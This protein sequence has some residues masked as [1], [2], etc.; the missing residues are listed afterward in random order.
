VILADIGA[1]FAKFV[2]GFDECHCTMGYV[3]ETAGFG[4]FERDNIDRNLAARAYAETLRLVGSNDDFAA[5][6]PR[7][8]EAR[9][10]FIQ[11]NWRGAV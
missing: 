5:V 3:H 6:E 10:S 2:F 9:A 11:M 4:Q 7:L 8:R 1:F